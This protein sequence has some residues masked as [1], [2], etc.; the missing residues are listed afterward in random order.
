MYIIAY[1]KACNLQMFTNLTR[2]V[3]KAF[4]NYRKIVVYFLFPTY[5]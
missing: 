3:T 4:K 5:E 1:R 2:R